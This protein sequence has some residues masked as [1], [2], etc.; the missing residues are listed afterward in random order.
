MHRSEVYLT[1][2]NDRNYFDLRAMHFEVQEDTLESSRCARND[3]QPWV[4]PSFDYAY[5]PDVPMAGGELNIKVNARE[6]VRD[7][8]DAVP[9]VPRV[10]GIEGSN[11][12]FTAEAEWKRSI[13]TDGGM[14]ISPLL[15][16]RGDAVMPT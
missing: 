9:S 11:G 3:K 13:V 10:R 7:E 8:L 5:T 1:G 16:V 15:A 14:V 4:L 6:I 12:R 2:L